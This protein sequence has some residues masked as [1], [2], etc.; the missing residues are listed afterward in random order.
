M[1]HSNFLNTD[2]PQFYCLLRKQF[3]YDLQE[4]RGVGD[5]VPCCVFG[6]ASIEGYAITFHVMLENGAQIARVP[7]HSLCTKP[8]APVWPLDN[9]EL[10]DC[11]GYYVAAHCFRY[12]K[13]LRVDYLDKAKAWHSGTYMF[14][15]DW[16]ASAL[17][18]DSGEGGHKNAHVIRLDNGNFVAAP[19]NRL[20]WREPSFI[21]KPYREGESPDYT[22]NSHVW[23]AET[24]SKWRTSSE[25]RIFYDIECDNAQ[26]ER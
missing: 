9:H 24:T 26:G 20:Q 17:S 8:D 3:L 16:A 21:T 13:A 25:N 23:K 18:E 11:F 6:V 7:I 5:Y 10:W 12:L 22:T 14:T 1:I 15:L 4:V 19:N 2:I